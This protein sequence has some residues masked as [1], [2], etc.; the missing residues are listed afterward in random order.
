[1]LMSEVFDGILTEENSM[2]TIYVQ[3]AGTHIVEIDKCWATSVTDRF[4]VWVM[5]AGFGRFGESS[6]PFA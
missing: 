6:L 3:V 1:M 4:S 5:D 2:S